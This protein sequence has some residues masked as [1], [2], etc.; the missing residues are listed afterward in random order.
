MLKAYRAVIIYTFHQEEIV[1]TLTLQIIYDSEPRFGGNG[2]VKLSGT[3]NP[4]LYY[5]NAMVYPHELEIS[6]DFKS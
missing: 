4:G 2:A 1:V 5:R 3:L 6:Y